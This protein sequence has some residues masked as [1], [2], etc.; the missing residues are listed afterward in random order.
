MMDKIVQ[1]SVNELARV[2]EPLA[3]M[4]WP[5]R[6]TQRLDGWLLRFSDGYSSRCNSVSTLE[7]HGTLDD[8]IG[9][10]EAAYRAHGLVPQFQI[11][12]ATRPDGLE[13]ALAARG[14]RHK[15]PTVLMI[16]ESASVA[17]PHHKARVLATPDTDFVRLTLE[18]S[19][20]PADGHERLATL[21]RIELAKAYMVARAGT[22][23]VSCGAS[24]VTGDWASVYVMRTSLIHRRQ[25]HGRRILSGIADW[26]LRRGA[27]RLYLQVDESNAAGRALYARAGFRDAYRYLHY[28]APEAPP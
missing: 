18:G 16:A 4:S 23:T 7:F 5:A 14:Y 2:L 21:A 19:H 8:A 9:A 25:G 15:P 10:V 3:V 27:S 26:A 22:E 12:P 13:Q 11:S 24:V 1:Y 17:A 20:S 28:Y 6:K